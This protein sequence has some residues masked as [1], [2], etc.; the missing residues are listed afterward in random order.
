MLPNVVVPEFPKDIYS[1]NSW[2][3]GVVEEFF[4]KVSLTTEDLKKQEQ[5]LTKIERE[6]TSKNI[7]YEDFLKTLDIEI[8]FYINDKEYVE[9]Y[10]QM[11]Q[12][13]NQFNLTTKRYTV[14]D[15]QG[16]I[17]SSSYDVIAVNYKDKFA[18][19]GI[20]GLVIVN[21][22][23]NYV[24]IDSFLLSCRVL[25]RGVEDAIFSKLEELYSDKD[26]VGVYMPTKKNEQTKELYTSHG[27]E[28]INKNKFIKKVK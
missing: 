21:I 12:K 2:F 5:Y 1:I 26:I 24:E 16:F 4:S 9:R 18:N 11:T 10:A 22:L 23:D 25:K 28:E 3:L 15:T 20:T 6:S 19:E 7:S 13:T 14:A 27:F 8:D 17:S